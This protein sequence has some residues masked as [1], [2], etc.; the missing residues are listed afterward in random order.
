MAKSRKRRARSALAKYPSPDT[1]NGTPV[2]DSKRNPRAVADLPPSLYRTLKIVQIL[3]QA[4]EQFLFQFSPFMP[5]ET[6]IAARKLHGEVTHNLSIVAD[7][8]ARCEE[9]SNSKD[10]VAPWEGG[11]A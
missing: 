4:T 8:L 5:D 1:I 9:G 2:S 6:G 10:P 7:V 11:D 3:M